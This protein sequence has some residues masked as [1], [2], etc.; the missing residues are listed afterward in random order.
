MRCALCVPCGESLV[1]QG[2]RES[3]IETVLVGF[4]WGV[5]QREKLPSHAIEWQKFCTFPTDFEHKQTIKRLV[6]GW[7]ILALAKPPLVADSSPYWGGPSPSPQMERSSMAAGSS[8]AHVPDWCEIAERASR[9]SDPKKLIQLVRALCDRL[10]EAEL[11]K[12]M[13][14][15][16]ETLPKSNGAL[17]K[18]PAA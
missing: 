12:R 6:R 16:P 1:P 10:Q 4:A 9:E 7:R 5:A 13:R 2:T 11:K 3:Q 14:P 17:A 8:D 15:D 18:P